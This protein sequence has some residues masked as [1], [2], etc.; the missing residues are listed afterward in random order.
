[1]GQTAPLAIFGETKEHAVGAT[2]APDP[3]AAMSAQ[4]HA[5]KDALAPWHAGYDYYEF[6]DIPAPASAVSRPRLLPPPAENQGRLRPRPGHHLRPP[7]PA[8]PAV[9]TPRPAVQAT[10]IPR[11]T[12]HRR[13]A[14]DVDDHGR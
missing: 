6:A 3:A 9:T 5:V 8:G 14:T 1:M 11:T 10:R 13:P 12:D 2:P 4:A 7:R